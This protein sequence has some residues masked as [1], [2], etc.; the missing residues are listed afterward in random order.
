MDEIGGH[1][2]KEA[3]GKWCPFFR[4]AVAT[5]RDNAFGDENPNCIASECMAWMPIFDKAQSGKLHSTK[6]G[7]CG[8][9]GKPIAVYRK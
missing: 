9:I 4:S 5:N 2:E 7:L 6:R 8:F 1:T 3:K